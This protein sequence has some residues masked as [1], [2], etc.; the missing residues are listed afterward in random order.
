MK[1]NE[2]IASLRREKG[3][4]QEALA[5]MLGVSTQAVSKWE[6]AASMPDIS[7]LPRLSEIFDVSVDYL[8]GCERNVRRTIDEVIAEANRLSG[9][10][11]HDES[12]ALLA[13]TLARYPGDN[14][15]TFELARHRFVN[16]RHKDRSGR[17]T[18]LRL[19]EEGFETVMRNTENE[20][21]RAW[22]A[23]F[24]SVIAFSRRDFDN[25]RYYN[26]KLLGGVGLY[27]RAMRVTID[28][29]EK[30]NRDSMRL[31]DE[32][33]LGCMHEYSLLVGLIAPY[34]FEHNDNALAIRE[35]SRA[36]RVL[37]EF[38]ETGHFD[39]TLMQCHETLA[40]AYA[41]S[42]RRDEM[43]LQLNLACDSAVRYDNR[44]QIPDYDVYAVMGESA[45]TEEKICAADALY[46]IL[47]SPDW[48]FFADTA[49]FDE[50][51]RRLNEK[52]DAV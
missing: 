51:L 46:R 4:T 31:L 50:I 29:E 22:A 2:T 10:R 3:Y 1:L 24:L 23:H 19:A 45:E 49:G 47:T 8:L 39:L 17:E 25:A 14:R 34:A 32:T 28:M 12:T 6:C 7:L 41:W 35:Y 37:E 27:P 11:M 15:L 20:N 30:A 26:G 36:V 16:A 42:D 33:V 52:T 44:K 40:R 21:R 18:L 48:R 13:R 38:N 5:E 43:I 9:Q